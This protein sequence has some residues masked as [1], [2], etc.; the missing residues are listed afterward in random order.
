MCQTEAYPITSFTWI[1]LYSDLAYGKRT[2][3]VAEATVN[4]VKWLTGGE[5]QAIAAS[6]HYAS[7]PQNA[8]SQAAALLKGITY[9]GETLLK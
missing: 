9:D 2:R 5:G 8:A 7:L 1:I 3:E 4:A 6:V